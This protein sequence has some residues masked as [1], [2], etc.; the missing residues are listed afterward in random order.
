[1]GPP[2]HERFLAIVKIGPRRPDARTSEM[3]RDLAEVASA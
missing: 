2:T 1:M 3:R